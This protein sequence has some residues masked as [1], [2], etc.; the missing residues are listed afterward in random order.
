MTQKHAKQAPWFIL[1]GLFFAWLTIWA[2]SIP[3]QRLADAIRRAEGPRHP[4]GVISVYVSGPA[5]A[6]RVCL[7]T[8]RHARARW[9]AAGKPGDFV[10]WLGSTY[11]PGP[12]R[13]R[14]ISLVKKI[15]K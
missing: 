10:A 1:G 4:Y 7:R 12:D 9:T 15:L 5:E 6:R 8:I 13:A 11:C 14:W 2:G 3:D